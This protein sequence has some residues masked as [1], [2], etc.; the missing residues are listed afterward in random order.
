M[1]LLIGHH[2]AGVGAAPKLGS[3]N[4]T[5]I[6]G[7][8]TL[9]SVLPSTNRIHVLTTAVP[10]PTSSPSSVTANSITKNKQKREKQGEKTEQ[11]EREKGIQQEPTYRRWYLWRLW[12][13][14]YD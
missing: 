3:P 8:A 6:R 1:T 11:D 14:W 13:H 5:T 10:V 2:P 4:A 12:H 7:L 9:L